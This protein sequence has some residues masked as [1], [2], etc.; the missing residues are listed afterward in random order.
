MIPQRIQDEE[1]EVIEYADSNTDVVFE[2]GG[3][4]FGKMETAGLVVAVILLIALIYLA[5][6][7]T[8]PDAPMSMSMGMGA[9]AMRSPSFLPPPPAKKGG[10][11]KGAAKKAGKKS[12]GKKKEA[13][14]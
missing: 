3:M 1:V 7:P 14:M 2:I 5:F 13:M 8:V 6:V 4:K 10:A 9:A 11:K 12:G